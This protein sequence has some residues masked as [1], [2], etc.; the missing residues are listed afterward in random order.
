MVDPL[1]LEGKTGCPHSKPF[2][3]HDETYQPIIDTY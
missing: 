3:V 1:H 2:L